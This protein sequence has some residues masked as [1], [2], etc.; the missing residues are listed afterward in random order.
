A[1]DREIEVTFS[2]DKAAMTGNLV[3]LPDLPRKP[4]RHEIAVTRGL[5]DSMALRRACHDK[6]LHAKLAP[7]GEQAR[8]IFDAVE[9]AR[10][11]AIGARTMP[12][13]ADNLAEMLE[14]RFSKANLSSVT[15]RADAPLDAAIALM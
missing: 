13:V 12:G 9:Q 3:R 5:G 15:E 6:A 7:Q 4:S 10:V 14:D 2:R 1:G 8:A 11:E